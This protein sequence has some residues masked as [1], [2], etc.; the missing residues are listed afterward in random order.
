MCYTK[1]IMNKNILNTVILVSILSFCLIALIP[2]E[3]KAE[4]KLDG[5]KCSSSQTLTQ[6]LKAPRI[7]ESYIRNGKYHW[8]TKQTV[9]E[10]HILQVHLNRLGFNTGKVDG[11]IGPN[12]KGAILRLQEY[13]G[14]IKD[15]YVGPLTRALLNNSCYADEGDGNDEADQNQDEDSNDSNGS[16][17]SDAGEKI[18]E[19]GQTMIDNDEIVRGSCWDFINATFNRAG[20]P[21][22]KRDTILSGTKNSGPYAD[23]SIIEPGDW[24]YYINYSYNMVEHSGVFVEWVDYDNKI[25]KVLGYAG[26]NRNLPGRYREFDLKSV[27]NI[28]RARD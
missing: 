24:M 19:M 22:S 11:V 4:S 15:G 16:N 23:I 21:S 9:K 12:T 14:T 18:L 13:L 3:A 25:A 10:V 5:Q 27:Y 28:I 1:E 7:G 6:N 26:E 17:G 2:K 20:Y 8:Y